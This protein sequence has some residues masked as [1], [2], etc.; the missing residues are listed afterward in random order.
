MEQG[1]PITHFN[2]GDLIIRCQPARYM[3]EKY[4]ETL[5]TTTMVLQRTDNSFMTEPVKLLA[6]ENGVIYCKKPDEAKSDYVYKLSIHSHS[7][8]WMPFT[9]PE[10]MTIEQC[11]DKY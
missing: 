4:N 10:G 5:M 3:E 8:N 1:Y 2:P 6:I 9:V 7:E 11:I